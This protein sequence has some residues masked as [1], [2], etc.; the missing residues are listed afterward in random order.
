MKYFLSKNFRTTVASLVVVLSS[1]FNVIVQ[2][3][4]IMVYTWLI[5]ADCIKGAGGTGE[6]G[7]L[8]S[9]ILVKHNDRV[10]V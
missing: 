9:C 10:L 6:E 8:I 3:Y 1:S 4:V 7:G 5:E 2:L